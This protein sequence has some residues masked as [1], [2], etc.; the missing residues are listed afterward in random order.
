[1]SKD[2]L[3]PQ[4]PNKGKQ[5]TSDSTN[6][7]KPTDGAAKARKALAKKQAR[8]QTIQVFCANQ[9]HAMNLKNTPSKVKIPSPLTDENFAIWLKQIM[10]SL[11]FLFLNH[12]INTNPR[13]L[14]GDM[15]YIKKRC[16]VEFI[17]SRMDNT[18][19]ERFRSQN[20]EEMGNDNAATSILWILIKDHHQIEHKASIFLIQTKLNNLKQKQNISINS[21]IN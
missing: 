14:E 13:Y 15:E 18:N 1:M 11:K 3:K 5:L 19:S 16:R 10:G 4:V 6:N 8:A 17:F 12:F 7:P 2:P 9:E 21:H 20:K